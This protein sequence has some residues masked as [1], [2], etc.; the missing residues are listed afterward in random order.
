[1]KQMKTGNHIRRAAK[2]IQPTKKTKQT[3]VHR[4]ALTPISVI[5]NIGTSDI[6]LDRAESDILSDIGINFYPISN[7]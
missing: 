4:W 5:S 1:M 2:N 7:I 3:F 6:G